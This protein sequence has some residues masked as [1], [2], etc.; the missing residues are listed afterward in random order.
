MRKTSV[1]TITTALILAVCILTA[2]C[3]NNSPSG[4][5]IPDLTGNWIIGNPILY[6]SETGFSEASDA[7]YA[8]LTG[9]EQKGRL[10][11]MEM[12]DAQRTYYLAVSDKYATH[13]F[14]DSSFG[15]VREY[16]TGNITEDGN[17][18]LFASVGYNRETGEIMAIFDP[19]TKEGSA[20]MEKPD[21]KQ[22]NLTGTWNLDLHTTVRNGELIDRDNVSETYYAAVG[23]SSRILT[24]TE[25]RGPVFCGT[26]QIGSYAAYEFAGVIT[27]I[28]DRG[29]SAVLMDNDGKFWELYFYA[30]GGVGL[31]EISIERCGSFSSTEMSGVSLPIPA[32]AGTW[33]SPSLKSLGN[34]GYEEK[35]L[36]IQS[37]VTQLKDM[38][39]AKLSNSGSYVGKTSLSGRLNYVGVSPSNTTYYTS[40]GFLG[41]DG[42]LYTY[43][44]VYDTKT[45]LPADIVERIY[46]AAKSV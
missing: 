21:G 6:S 24:V 5:V 32:L 20:P 10:V 16:L 39:T 2:G 28:S 3:V 29:R 26:I 42:K 1:L 43:T 19:R 45:G 11:K 22:L 4:E 25:A 41:D 13:L 30:G 27:H 15:N 37:E 44:A 33:N 35:E 14:S 18:I 8:V 23:N 31:W 40:E 38:L 12:K 17:A 9:V 46:T 36:P 34:D 7:G